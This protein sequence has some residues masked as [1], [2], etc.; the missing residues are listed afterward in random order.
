VI[1]NLLA[2]AVD[3]VVEVLHADNLEK[4]SAAS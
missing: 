2:A 1:E 3:N 4:S